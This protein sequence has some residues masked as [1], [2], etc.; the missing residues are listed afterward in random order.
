[1]KGMLTSFLD[2][3]H[4]RAEMNKLFEALQN[5]QCTEDVPDSG[6]VTPY[7]ILET[8]E[9]ILVEVDL[10]G[11]NPE[12]LKIVA[13]GALVTI[14]GERSRSNNSGII[15][16]HLMERDRGGF[17][18]TLTVDG[19]LDTHRATADYRDGVLSIKFPRL[20]ERRGRTT[21]IPLNTEG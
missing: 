2:I 6:T 20:P 15:A 21:R 1:M 16:Y 18:R 11:V 9:Y 7:D 10:P 4:L 8:S 14:Q 3:V 5:L 13:R 19:A 17:T 12:N